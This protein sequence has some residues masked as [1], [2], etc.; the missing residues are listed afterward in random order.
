M[1]TPRRTHSSFLG[2][3]TAIHT[4]VRKGVILG[5]EVKSMDEA[6]RVTVPAFFV[7]YIT[8]TS[9]EEAFEKAAD[10]VWNGVQG[11]CLL[12]HRDFSINDDD[13]SEKVEKV[14]E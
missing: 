1:G 3:Y 13:I 4:Q 11:G 6:Y 5:M 7:Y 2:S 14:T 10:D 9:P 12:N 8:A